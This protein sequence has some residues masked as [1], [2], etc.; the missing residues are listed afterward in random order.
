MM[1]VV[2]RTLSI[3]KRN[4]LFSLQQ[5]TRLTLVHIKPGFKTVWIAQ[6]NDLNR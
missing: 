5:L 4:D 6:P 3:L 1:D 2:K